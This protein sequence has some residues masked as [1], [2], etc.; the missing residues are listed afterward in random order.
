MDLSGFFRSL[1]RQERQGVGYYDREGRFLRRG[2]MSWLDLLEEGQTAF[3][4]MTSPLFNLSYINDNQAIPDEEKDRLIIHAVNS[5][6][7]PARATFRSEIIE[8]AVIEKVFRHLDH[9]INWLNS[10]IDQG[11]GEAFVQFGPD[12]WERTSI[13]FTALPRGGCNSRKYERSVYKR[14]FNNHSLELYNPKSQHNDCGIEA[15]RFFCEIPGKNIKIRKE[16]G[17]EYE[18]KIP[19]DKMFEIYQKYN[20]TDKKLVIHELSVFRYIDVER[21]NN[22]I[23]SKEHYYAVSGAERE[24]TTESIMPGE[25]GYRLRKRRRT[26]KLFFDYETREDA[27]GKLVPTILAIQEKDNK[28]KKK[29]QQIF[30]TDNESTCTRKFIDFL[31]KAHLMGKHY[32]CMAF[33]GSRFDFY[34]VLAELTEQELVCTQKVLRGLSVIKFDFQAHRFTDPCNFIQSTLDEACKN[35]KV[36]KAKITETD[37]GSSSQLCFYKRHLEVDAFMQLRQTEPEFWKVYEEYCMRDVEALDELW[38]KFTNEFYNITKRIATYTKK[39]EIKQNKVADIRLENMLTIAGTAKKIALGSISESI[40]KKY[41]SF[42]TSVPEELLRAAV[43]GGISYSTKKGICAE[44]VACV[45]IT[46]Q[47]TDAMMNMEVPVGEARRVAEYYP[48]CHGFYKL[49]N[50]QFKDKS[51]KPFA[52]VT[53]EGSLDWNA[54]FIEEGV[55]GTQMMKYLIEKDAMKFEVVEGYISSKSEK[56]SLFFSKFSNGFFDEKKR[57]DHLKELGDEEYNPAMRSVTK[58][59][60][61]SLSGKLVENPKK[62]QSFDFNVE[63]DNLQING[64]N[65]R[66]YTANENKTNELLHLGLCMYE[67]SKLNLFKT[68]DAVGRDNILCAETDSVTFPSR[69]L[70]LLKDKEWFGKGLGQIN[71]DKFSNEFIDVGKK[72]QYF[73]EKKMSWKGCPQKQLDCTGK[74]YQF[75]T[76]QDYIDLVEGKTVVKTFTSLKKYLFGKHIEIKAEKITRTWKL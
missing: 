9:F 67:Y 49:K 51:F 54:D 64:V 61:N 15:L 69:F 34:F 68:I 47:Y 21:D 45:D 33:N 50:I 13:E 40:K 28:T 23:L 43:R 70:P 65:V 30:R 71:V 20:K 37:Y 6:T 31:N 5:V 63:S 57:Q 76:K 11:Y 75:I 29:K 60:L 4:M 35:F 24:I 3:E 8:G 14:R 46:S 58:L 56:G 32:H 59:F 25:E 48:K 62:Y 73:D 16:F 38:T 2:Q 39:G 52:R 53:E 44:E 10:F 55:M 42:N 36:E 27:S 12:A 19:I 41:T 1:E 7:F 26:H 72:M 18:E 22:I 17:L 74:K 66:K